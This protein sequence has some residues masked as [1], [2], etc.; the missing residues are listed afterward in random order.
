MHRN[1]LIIV[2]VIVLIIVYTFYNRETYVSG[3]YDITPSIT[4]N[5]D[6]KGATLSR[7]PYYTNN[8]INPSA[9]ALIQIQELQKYQAKEDGPTTSTY[10]ANGMSLEKNA[11]SPNSREGFETIEEFTMMNPY[12]SN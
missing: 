3:S 5:M 10:V 11:D 9:N 4:A 6:W 2:L 7:Y 12:V 8:L 1:I